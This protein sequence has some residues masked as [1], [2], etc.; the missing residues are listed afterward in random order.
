MLSHLVLVIC[1]L[2]KWSEAQANVGGGNEAGGHEDP[3]RSAYDTDQPQCG[4]Q[5]IALFQKPLYQGDVLGLCLDRSSKCVDFPPGWSRMVESVYVG[6]EK[7]CYMLFT[8]E[9]C[10]GMEFKVNYRKVKER[11]TENLFDNNLA[12]R[13]ASIRVCNE[14]ETTHH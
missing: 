12:G 10:D 2:V 3:Y 5:G 4:T 7:A 1:V 8:S 11:K 9:N 14:Y 13:H 6:N